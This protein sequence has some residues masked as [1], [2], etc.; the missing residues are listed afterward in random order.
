MR[1]AFISSI[2]LKHL[3]QIYIKHECLENRTYTEQYEIIQKEAISAIG[4]WPIHLKEIGIP[5]IM[6]CRNNHFIQDTWCKENYFQPKTE[7]T[8]FEIILEQV[9]RY[10]A[11]H[12]FIFGASYYAHGNRLIKIQSKCPTIRKRITW[13][14]APEGNEKIFKEYDLVLTPSCKLQENLDKLGICTKQIN[15]AFEPKTFDYLQPRKRKNKACFIGSMIPGNKWHQ[16]RIEYLEILGKN[17]DLEIY[18]EISKP[19]YFLKFKKYILETRSNMCKTLNRFYKRSDRINYLSDRGNLPIYDNWM[20]S[21]LLSKIK[22]S[23]Y[24]LDM[25]NTL[26]EYSITFNQH[27]QL[28]GDYAGNMRMLEATGLGCALITDMKLNLSNFFEPDKEVVAYNSKEEAVEK[29]NYLTDNPMKAKQIGKAGQLRCL[30]SHSTENQIN[31]LSEII[32]STL[33]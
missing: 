10:K 7:D 3:E 21:P 28:A 16:E 29:I 24:G 11:T 6:F 32:K 18:T 25:L 31:R 9:R 26:S 23:V 8:E 15:H 33:T 27:I 19:T 14:G 12:L 17:T 1:I 22:G 2:Y 30:K 4:R 20:G 13:Y 5:S